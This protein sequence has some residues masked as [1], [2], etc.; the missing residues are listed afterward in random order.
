MT[1]PE[2]WERPEQVEKFASRDPDHRL[3][4]LLEDYE[5]P[6]AVPVLDL[7]CA[8]GRNTEL[9]AREGFDVRAVDAS[10]A[11]VEATRRRVAGVLGP[12]EARRRVG[13]AR[14]DDLDFP[15]HAFRLVVALGVY[16][17]AE[18]PGEWR[19]ALDETTRVL[20]AG[21]RV[22]V[23]VFGPGTDLTGEGM[24][25][26]PGSEHLYSGAPSGRLYLLTAG[27]LDREMERRGLRPVEPTETVRVE[28][29]PGRRVTVNGLYE[30]TG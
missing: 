10:R 23:S 16:H 14:M 8:G 13:R 15:D 30:R 9:L 5:D 7:G 29:D 4:R 18:G 2:F 24:E 25:P 17:E 22:L 27:E 6:S 1:D 21:G 26:V 12:G 28:S 11:M 19:R 3:R 20:A